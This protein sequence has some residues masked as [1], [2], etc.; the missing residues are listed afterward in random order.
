MPKS[1]DEVDLRCC[2]CPTPG[3]SKEAGHVPLAHAHLQPPAVPHRATAETPP[4]IRT[5]RRCVIAGIDPA[6]VKE[7]QDS[8][9]DACSHGKQGGS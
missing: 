9:T 7:A 6:S 4:E 1:Y 8:K 5:K 2:T 3:Q